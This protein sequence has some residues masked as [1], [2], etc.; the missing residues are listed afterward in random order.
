MSLFNMKID[1][2]NKLIYKPIQNCDCGLTG[3]CEK[4]NILLAELEKEQQKLDDWKRRFD[5]DIDR[6][7]KNFLIHS[8]RELKV[9]HKNMKKIIAKLLWKINKR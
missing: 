7:S 6:R 8:Q 2:F 1:K 9:K 5:E 3:G 4:C